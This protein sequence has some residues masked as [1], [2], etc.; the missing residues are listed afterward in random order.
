MSPLS[1]PAC[2]GGAHESCWGIN[3]GGEPYVPPVDRSEVGQRRAL[4]EQMPSLEAID[5]PCTST[6]HPEQLLIVVRR[7]LPAGSPE[8]RRDALRVILEQLPPEAH[9]HPEYIARRL[10]EL[11]S[12]PEVPR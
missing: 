11:P 5:C 6:K 12:T 4:Y 7:L 9:E 8:L 1:C 2:L 10:H 3:H